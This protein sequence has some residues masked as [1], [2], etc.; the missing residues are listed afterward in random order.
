VG[1]AG[2]Q[3]RLVHTYFP[4]RYLRTLVIL[5]VLG[6]IASLSLACRGEADD[7]DDGTP[8]AIGGT[9]TATGSAT[10][11]ASPTAAAPTATATPTPDSGAYPDD[12]RTNIP[13]V[14]AVIDRVLAG[15]VASL[16]VQINYMTVACETNPQGV[17]SPPKCEGGEQQGTMV[18]AFPS[19]L[20]EMGWARPAQ[21]DQILEQLVE[22]GPKLYAIYRVN[23]EL[24]PLPADGHG[25]VFLAP[26]N[27]ART[28]R[29]TNDGILSVFLGCNPDPREALTGQD[30]FVL[31]PLD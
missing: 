10:T 18:E 14:D 16:K 7:V 27:R 6:S 28:V 19:A 9:P 2:A 3:G 21:V 24:G 5:L 22:G 30:D 13:S 4:R 1:A 29:V 25:V 23:E 31:S 8:T 17:G 20:C 26:D 12:T 11:A 15:D